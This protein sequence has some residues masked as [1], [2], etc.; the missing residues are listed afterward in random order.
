MSSISIDHGDCFSERLEYTAN[1]L[2][3]LNPG[4]GIDIGQCTTDYT[5]YA[6][7]VCCTAVHIYS[8]CILPIHTDTYSGWCLM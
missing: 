6:N 7:E 8:I 4:L 1:E 2:I 3:S 5:S